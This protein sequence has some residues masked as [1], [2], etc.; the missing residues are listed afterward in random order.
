MIFTGK[1]NFSNDEYQRPI[2]FSSPSSSGTIIN[3]PDMKSAELC[4]TV[5]KQL[6]TKKLLPDIT[7]EEKNTASSPGCMWRVA[8]L[9][10]E[11]ILFVINLGCSDTEITVRSREGQELKAVDLIDNSS[12]GISFKLRPYGMRLLKVD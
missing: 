11:S 9:D 5:Q 6:K 12:T 7:C 2:I 8:D 1:D 4:A 10:G 3:M